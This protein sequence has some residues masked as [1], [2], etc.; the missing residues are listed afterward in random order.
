MKLNKQNIFYVGA[1]YGALVTVGAYALVKYATKL[2][3][4]RIDKAI[5]NN[6][7]KEDLFGNYTFS[8]TY[9]DDIFR[10]NT[11]EENS[12]S[13]DDDTENTSANK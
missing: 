6:K 1:C 3:D 4:K 9:D 11:F 8:D 5:S 12:W 7:S 10:H 2:I 13:F